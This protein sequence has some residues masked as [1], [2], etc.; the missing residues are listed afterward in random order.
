[1]G[2][3][4]ACGTSA[5]RPG[6]GATTAGARGTSCGEDSC[7][8]LVE[9][10]LADGSRSTRSFDVAGNPVEVVGFD[11]TVI[12]REFDG[13]GDCVR[14]ERTGGAV[15]RWDHDGRG[16]LIGLVDEQG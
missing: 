11:R 14:E 5:H 1:M 3:V 8:R 2:G 4:A 13:R 7:G 16:R 9:L 15:R 10:Q 6:W 12:R